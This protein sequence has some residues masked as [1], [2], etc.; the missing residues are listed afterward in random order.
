M[1]VTAVTALASLEAS[2]LATSLR[3]SAWLYPSVATI[4][5]VGVAL[6]FGSIAVLDVRLLG[7]GRTL[8]VRKLSAHVLPWT[9][10]SFALILPSGLALF[11]AHASD[12]LTNDLFVVKMGLIFAGGCN[13]ALFHAAMA[14]ELDRWDSG[15][16]SPLGARI[17]GALSLLIWAAAIACGRWLAYV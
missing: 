2:S 17:A 7:L 3:D 13:A 5:L 1:A 8:S 11:V 6:L 9:V 10:L 4:H 12:Y 15:V 14:G 16:S